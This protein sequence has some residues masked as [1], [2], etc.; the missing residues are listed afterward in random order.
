MDLKPNQLI[1]DVEFQQVRRGYDPAEVDAFLDRIQAAME[2]LT[3]QLAE[4]RSRATAAEAQVVE[5]SNRPA[6]EAGAGTEQLQ[7]TLVLAQRTADAAVAEANEE[8]ESLRTAARADADRI[9]EEARTE[10]TRTA[11]EASEAALAELHASPPCAKTSRPTSARWR[12]T[13]TPSEA[14]WVR[15][16]LNCRVGWT[17]PSTSSRRVPS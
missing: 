14:A 9:V 15:P 17:I 10:A 1:G 2:K 7:R 6:P 5:L 16:S 8:A 13:S 12:R 3:I 4:A 11:E